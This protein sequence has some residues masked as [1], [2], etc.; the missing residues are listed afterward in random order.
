MLLVIPAL[1]L[2][3]QYQF[4]DFIKL[5]ALNGSWKIEGKKGTTYEIWKIENDTLMSAISYKVS[6]TD[7]VMLESVTLAFNNGKITYTPVTKDQE[8]K[9]SVVFPLVTITGTKF[10]FENKTHDFP[11][12]I[13]Y[14]LQSKQSLMASIS[15]PGQNGTKTINYPFEKLPD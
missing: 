6:A 7:T 12:L 3:A 2:S 14:D 9:G 15:G 1:H 5:H 13:T 11:Q 10:S 8:Q 4:N